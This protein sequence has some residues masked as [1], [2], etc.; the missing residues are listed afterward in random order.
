MERSMH[1]GKAWRV[2]VAAAAVA[3]AGARA[4][5]L[6]AN[7]ASVEHYVCLTPHSNGV[8]VLFDQ[9]FDAFG[10]RRVLVRTDLNQDGAFDDAEKRAYLGSLTGSLAPLFHLQ[11]RP[12]GG[13]AVDLPLR[14]RRVG[15][16]GG[17]V[18]YTL[19]AGAGEQTLRVRWTMDADW[20]EAV[21][22]GRR[23]FSLSYRGDFDYVA[24]LYSVVT[25]A[26]PPPPMALIRSTVPTPEALPMPPDTASPLEPADAVPRVMAASAEIAWSGNDAAASAAV[27]T[28][29]RSSVGA[30]GGVAAPFAAAEGRLRERVFGLLR[31]PLGAAAWAAC[32]ALCFAWG[33]M[34]AMSPGHGKAIVSAYLIGMHARVRHAVLVGTVVTLTHTAVV[35]VLAIAAVAMQDRFVFPRWL[36]PAGAVVIVLVGLNQL[37]IGL[38]R[39]AADRAHAHAHAHGH[40]HDH[41]HAHD[42]THSHGPTMRRSTGTITTMMHRTRPGASSAT[43]TGRCRAGHPRRRGNW[44]PWASAAAWCRVRRASSFCSLRSR[45][46][47]PCWGSRA[48]C[49]SAS[50]WPSP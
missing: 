34:H 3:A 10:A 39:F 15:E 25:I 49:P 43:P 31:P 46:R 35:I 8:A 30:P 48:S 24:N 4:H 11:A 26:A 28:V 6:A 2:A 45:S 29:R 9:H 22:A 38:A 50:A 27:E 12:V 32:L 19:G 23:P 5:H 33:A 7:L 13:D 47:S 18:C 14:A 37:R 16:E 44:S 41:T 36:Q 20:P 42:S 17:P 1:G 21:R 40:P